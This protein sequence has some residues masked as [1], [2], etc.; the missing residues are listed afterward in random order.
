MPS[1]A[2]AF[3]ISFYL[4]KSILVAPTSDPFSNV[5]PLKILTQPPSPKKRH[6]DQNEILAHF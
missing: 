2:L 1:Y 5:K 4:Q 6:A 3:P